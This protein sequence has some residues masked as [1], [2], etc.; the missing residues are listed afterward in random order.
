[1]ECESAPDTIRSYDCF[2]RKATLLVAWPQSFC[3]PMY[4]GAGG[5]GK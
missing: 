1:M 5:R 2:D 4:A 3:N